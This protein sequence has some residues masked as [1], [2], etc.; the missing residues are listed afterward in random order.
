MANRER[1]ALTDEERAQRR[2]QEREL[3]ER[4]VAQLRCSAGWQRWLSVRARVGLRRYS[5]RN[6]LLICLQDPHA[7][8]VAGFR[9]WLSLGYCV[10]CGETSHIRVWA[11]CAPSR[12]KLQAWRDAGA[13]PAGQ[14]KA[15]YRLEAVFSATQ[16]EALPPPSDPVALQP[17]SAELQG[18]SLAWAHEPLEELAG[19]LGYR[20][21]HQA[22][23][24]GHGGSCDPVAKVLTINEEQSVNAQVSVTC[25]ELAHALVRHDRRDDDP[26]LSYAE[27]ELVAES[28]AHLAVSFVGLD[29]SVAAVP[30]LAGWAEAAAPDT[31]ERIAELV[32]RLARRLE[33]ALGADDAAKPTAATD[34]AAAPA[35]D[36]TAA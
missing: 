32:D 35:A 7:T 24:R 21:V 28:V 29:S 13:V 33:T 5:V 30:Y 14:P 25:H 6:Q 34:D 15:Y 4:A 23:E 20:I 27:E 17:P 3:T 26:Q 9:A 11:R 1:I 36:R 31:F 16:V 12:K 22:L 8:H 10:R 18:D 2:K 19:E